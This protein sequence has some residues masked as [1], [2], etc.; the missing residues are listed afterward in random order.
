MGKGRSGRLAGSGA[1]K[2]AVGSGISL[3]SGGG[4]GVLLAD[5]PAFQEA[6]KVSVPGNWAW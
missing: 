1:L 6:C 4:N 2:A 5:D 3:M